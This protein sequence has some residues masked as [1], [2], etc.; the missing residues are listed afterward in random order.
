MTFKPLIKTG[1]AAAVTVLV[2]CSPAISQS[3]DEPVVRYLDDPAASSLTINGSST[4]HDWT[5]QGGRIPGFVTIKGGVPASLGKGEKPN[6]QPE[7]LQV[8]IP[9]SSL[10]GESEDMTESM[11]N[12]MNHEKHKKIR[13]KGTGMSFDRRINSNTVRMNAEGNV[14][15]S[16]TTKE[17]RLKVRVTR[18]APGRF[19]AT[20]RKNLKMTD[21]GIDPPTALAGTVTV[22][23]QVTVD[24]TWTVVKQTGA[25]YSAPSAIRRTNTA[26]LEDYEKARDAL[27]A[28]HAQN[29]RHAL[30]RMTRIT[31]RLDPSKTNLDNPARTD[32]RTLMSDLEQALTQPLTA[33]DLYAMKFG[34][35]PVSRTLKKLLRTLGHTRENPVAYLQCTRRDDSSYRW[36]GRPGSTCPYSTNEKTH[37]GTIR[38]FLAGSDR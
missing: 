37:G 9:V 36:L 11:Y 22:Y 33:G 20:A 31:D 3:S 14:T 23:D 25:R 10:S 35:R 17:L 28:G 38:R 29:A 8:S 2:F 1:W 32:L 7:S 19:R 5:V 30:K 26:L 12:A 27:V 15:V 16:G 4:L 21:F 24:L 6:I 18:L 34:L 13:F